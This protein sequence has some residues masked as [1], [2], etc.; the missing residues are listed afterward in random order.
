MAKLEWKFNG[1]SV[2]PSHAGDVIVSAIQDKIKK[3]AEQMMQNKVSSIK[4]PEHGK[5]PQSIRLE[6]SFPNQARI[7][8]DCC[9][10]KLKEE[11]GKALTN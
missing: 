10:D 11:V 5:T 2:S 6:G 9:C 1:Q 4:C 7:I 3:A 8:M